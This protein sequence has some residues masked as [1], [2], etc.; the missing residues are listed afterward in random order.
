MSD[1][2]CPA[3][4]D[5]GSLL[6]DACHSHGLRVNPLVGPSSIL[7]ALMASGLSGQ[8]FAFHGYLPV[9]K[10]ECSRKIRQLE[11]ESKKEGRSQILIETPY[12]N[13]AIWQSLIGNLSA[14]TKLCYAMGIG[15]NEEEIRQMMVKEWK[16]HPVPAWKK[17]P[18]IFLFM[19]S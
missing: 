12:R 15:S 17:V 14:E 18:A 9:D 3:V 13:A 8:N 1:A 7:L 4:A 10:A 16:K 11:I 19:A 6:V 2:G 5:P